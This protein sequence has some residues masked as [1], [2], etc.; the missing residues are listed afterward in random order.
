MS[1]SARESRTAGSGTGHQARW[2]RHN[3]V[4]QT[5]ILEAAVELL[6]ENPSGARIPMQQIAARAGLAKSV[7]YRQFADRDDL[8]RRIRSYLVD[9]F[10]GELF[11]KL[12]ITDGSIEEI[13]NR[14]IHTVAD[15]MAEHPR[16]HEFMRSG[17]THEDASVD[18][19]SSLKARMA[20]R[21]R[22]I[23]TAVSKTID[24]DD[25]GFESLT[26]AIV[27][28]VEGMLTQWVRDP[29]PAKTRS[30]I[31]AELATYAWYMLDGAARSLGLVLDPRA[32]LLAVIGQLAGAD[33]GGVTP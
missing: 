2:E 15:W 29:A 4:R 8:D 31:V 11:T 12:D 3:S 20:A 24:V 30:E 13:L 22:A 19:V 27:T 5:R 9:V 21:A 10:A 6:E 7:V 18:A 23:I 26:L 32:E 14:T 17:P 1:S 28:M 25:S 33:R 16:L